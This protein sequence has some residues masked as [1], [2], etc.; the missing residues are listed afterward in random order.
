MPGPGREPDVFLVV[1]VVDLQKIAACDVCGLVLPGIGE[2][3]ISLFVCIHHLRVRSFLFRVR[4]FILF[5]QIRD[6]H[7]APVDIDP[8]SEQI[9][10][11]VFPVQIQVDKTG[12]RGIGKSQTFRGEKSI[13]L[14]RLDGVPE[15]GD[16][17]IFPAAAHVQKDVFLVK[18]QVVGPLFLRPGAVAASL[19]PACPAGIRRPVGLIDPVDG[20]LRGLV[21]L[22]CVDGFHGAACRFDIHG[23]NIFRIVKNDCLR[24]E[25]LP[26]CVQDREQAGNALRKYRERVPMEEGAGDSSRFARAVCGCPDVRRGPGGR[27]CAGWSAGGDAGFGRKIRGSFC[28]LRVSGGFCPNRVS[29]GFCLIRVSGGLRNDQLLPFMEPDLQR[30]VHLRGHIGILDAC[31]RILRQAKIRLLRRGVFPDG[32]SINGCA[33]SRFCAGKREPRKSERRLRGASGRRFARRELP[34]D[35]GLF[36]PG[37]S[38]NG[39]EKTDHEEQQCRHHR[40]WKE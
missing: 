29:G 17:G 25:G 10:A 9:E 26:L 11:L 31:L 18:I 39:R 7:G 36:C 15:I 14:A 19:D 1:A 5:I 34:A 40:C 24:T 30:T 8:L 38:R 4:F 27:R 32:I 2:R 23:G 33:G 3:L 12:L 35:E 16:Q 21:V 22:V 20:F 6:L 37:R 13:V 28:P